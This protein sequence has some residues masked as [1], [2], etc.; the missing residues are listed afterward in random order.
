M[1]RGGELRDRF[2]RA[3]HTP[4]L[5]RI[6]C[7]GT[8][9][10]AD[11]KEEP[12]IVSRDDLEGQLA[13][14]SAEVVE[15]R[16]GI[17]GPGTMAW[18]IGKESILFLG[19]GCAALLQIAHPYVAHA[20]DQ[21]SQTRTDPQGRFVRTFRNVFA[22]VFGD[23]ERAFRAARRVHAIH[24]RVTGEITED[25]GVFRRGH[26]YAANDAESLLWVHATLLHTA[27][28][29][30]ERFVGRL[31]AASKDRYYAES[32]RFAYLFGIPDSVLPADWPAFVRYFDAMIASST[33]AVGRPAAEI[34]AFLLQPPR[35]AAA[36]LFAWYET[37]TV[38]LLPER[39]RRDFGFRFGARERAVFLASTVGIR[40][41]YRLAPRG[42]R[43]LPDYV[44]ARRR[45]ATGRETRWRPGR[46]A[47]KIVARMVVARPASA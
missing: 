44:E 40:A 42:L 32:R 38:G 36:P 43:Y 24:T 7:N 2:E 30:Y 15:P 45:V 16:R 5:D 37:M 1:E 9:A 12:M 6:R 27:V 14:V 31:D 18:R 39:F 17:H 29:V 25:V 8:F 4:F 11:R 41:G 34:A 33:L 35:R 13:R 10:P 22:M 46:L 28:Q 47:E 20:V 3:A 19:G 21:H 23:L 26:R